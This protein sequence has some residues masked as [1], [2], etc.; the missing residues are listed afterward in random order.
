ME[1]AYIQGFIEDCHVR[2]V[3]RLVE[4][5]TSTTHPSMEILFRSLFQDYGHIYRV[6][7]FDHVHL[8]YRFQ[9]AVYLDASFERVLRKGSTLPESI[10]AKWENRLFL[11]Y[12]AALIDAEGGIRLYQNGRRADSVLYITINKYRLLRK[13][14]QLLGGRL[15]RHDRAWRLVF[16][17]KKASLILDA[18][19][20]RHAEKITKSA[21]V[22]GARGLRWVEV[23]RG[24][25]SIVS[26]IRSEVL[27]YR[28]S[29]KTDYILVH[30]RPHRKD[31]DSG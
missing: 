16:Y 2:K 23:E 6:A 5:S 14:K 21:F 12:L 17:G 24:W 28:D 30:G 10:P 13:L 8:F 1:A 22:R 31:K 27:R 19:E 25:K 18:L 11:Q 26:Q 20:L 3:G 7:S 29:A 15:Y 4:V 9:F